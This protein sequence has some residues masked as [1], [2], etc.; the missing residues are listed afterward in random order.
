MK[1]LCYIVSAIGKERVT[2]SGAYLSF[3]FLFSLETES[4]EC[5]LS[6]VGVDLPITFKLI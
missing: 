5:V 2:S 1:C 6:I 4:L 3:A